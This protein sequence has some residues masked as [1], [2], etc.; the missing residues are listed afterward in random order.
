M[1]S[2]PTCIDLRL[3]EEYAFLDCDGALFN[4]IQCEPD[5][6][7]YCVDTMTGLRLND[8]VVMVAN[9]STLDCESKFE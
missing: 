4:D 7:C 3:R 6:Q 5:G 2:S 9:R 1:P 8:V